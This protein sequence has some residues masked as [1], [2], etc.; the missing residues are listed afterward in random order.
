VPSRPPPGVR[1]RTCLGDITAKLWGLKRAAGQRWTAPDKIPA[2]ATIAAL[3]P[4]SMNVRCWLALLSFQLPPGA[5]RTAVVTLGIGALVAMLGAGFIFRALAD[6]RRW[7]M[8]DDGEPLSLPRA[9]RCHR[10]AA[11]ASSP[12]SAQTPRVYRRT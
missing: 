3:Q 9:G 8:P 4:T 2:P 1:L 6:R 7:R 5:L 11:L 10:T 12:S